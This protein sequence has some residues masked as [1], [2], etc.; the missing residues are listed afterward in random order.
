SSVQRLSSTIWISLLLLLAS[1]ECDIVNST[2]HHI[3]SSISREITP[4]TFA[5]PT[6]LRAFW[7][8]NLNDSALVHLDP[9][10]LLIPLVTGSSF[11]PRSRSFFRLREIFTLASRKKGSQLALNYNMHSLGKTINELHAMLKLHEQTLPKNNAP[12]LHVIRAGHWKRYCPQYL[13]E[14]LKKKKNATSRVGGSCIFVIELN[15]IL[16]RSWIYDTGCGTHISNTTHGLRAN[17]M[18][19][20]IDAEE[21]E[22]GD[23]GE[24]ANYKAALLDLKFEKWLN[25]M[26]VEMQSMKDY[27]VLVLV[28]LP[29][30]GKTI[31][32]K[33]LFKKKTDMDRVVY[34]YKALLLEKGYTQTSG[35]DYEETFSPVADIRAIRI[36]IA[37]AAYYNYK[38]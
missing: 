8:N 35:I 32:S 2:Q 30:N 31:V 1:I 15:T 38:I 5:Q 14:L 22:L 25:A 27:E 37:I 36:L 17:R 18:C 21:H 28:K 13:A 11:R 7:E 23:L 10:W 26:N 34:T 9:T 24:P 4:A 29:P 6:L 19:L 20:Y 33:W 3:D 16:N 12:T